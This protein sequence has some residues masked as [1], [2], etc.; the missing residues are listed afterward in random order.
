MERKI[1]TALTF[2]VGL[3]LIAYG[4]AVGSAAVAIVGMVVVVSDVVIYAVLDIM[5]ARKR[6]EP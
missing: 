2:I 5:A 3:G 1:G 4:G 6:G